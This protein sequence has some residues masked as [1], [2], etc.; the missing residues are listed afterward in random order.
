MTNNSMHKLTLGRSSG[1]TLIELLVVVA[2]IGILASV[3]LA[4]L[5]SARNKGGDA[6]IKANLANIRAQAE[7]IYDGALCYNEAGTP[8]S[9]CTNYAVGACSATPTANTLFNNASVKA[10]INGA[11]TASGGVYTNTGCV[12][13]TSGSVAQTWAASVPLKSSTTSSWC[14]DSTGASRSVTPVGSDR[15]FTGGLCKP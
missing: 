10:Q 13:S 1:F 9:T 15:G 5:N 2:I 14:V 7:I 8:G 12:S 4:S 3:V 6:A 11:V